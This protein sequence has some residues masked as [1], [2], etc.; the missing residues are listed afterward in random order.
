M[1]NPKTAARTSR[2]NLAGEIP[3]SKH[4]AAS[5]SGGKKYHGRATTAANHKNPTNKSVTAARV[6][7]ANKGKILPS[8]LSS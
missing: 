2:G 4:A 7:P 8:V 3:K 6:A 1:R 5:A